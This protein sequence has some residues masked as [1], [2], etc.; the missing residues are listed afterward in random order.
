MTDRR[1]LRSNGR[2]AH[3]SLAGEV[4]AER[5]VEGE[6][7][8]VV[9]T[10]A[11]LWPRLGEGPQDRELWFGEEFVVLDRQAIVPD[12]ARHAFGFCARDGAVG[13]VHDSA[14]DDPVK[15]THKIAVARSYAKMSPALKPTE[16]IMYMTYGT[17][18][19]V[20]ETQGDWA[21]FDAGW[22][23]P[24]WM[25]ARHLVPVGE[26]SADPV[27]VA[28]LFLG[29]PYLWGGNSAY[30]ID[31]S[32]LVQAAMHACGWACA[33]DSDLQAAMPGE[34][35]S[36]NAALEPGDLIFWKGHV[37][38]ATG[39]E[40]MIHANAHHMMVVEESIAAA[41][42]RIVATDTGPVTLRLRPERR[43]LPTI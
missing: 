23:M 25:P 8:R 24:S 21:R 3:V 43:P 19:A 17:L 22:D 14:L 20:I 35:L 5:F 42:A 10:F 13:W 27:A 30:G 1:L 18:V 16:D 39:P 32:G 4:E 28:R 40:T 11:P 7:Q 37:A 9:G 33:P 34:R 15:A 26:V 6:R 29:T 36:D 41:V 12:G 31:C 38:I 2:V